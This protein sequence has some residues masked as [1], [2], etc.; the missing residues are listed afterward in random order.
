MDY[1]RENRIARRKSNLE[2]AIEGRKNKTEPAL[3]PG[4][5]SMTHNLKNCLLMVDSY[6]DEEIA[7]EIAEEKRQKAAELLGVQ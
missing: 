7:E 1:D 4:Q 3:K 2:M 6:V 5:I